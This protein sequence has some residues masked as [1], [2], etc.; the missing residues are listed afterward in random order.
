MEHESDGNTNN[1]R[2]TWYFHQRINTKT[3]GRRNKKT[4][5][6]HSNYSIVEISQNTKK[7]SGDLRRLFVTHTP[8][9]NHPLTQSGFFYDLSNLL[10]NFCYILFEEF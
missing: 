8:M 7:S 6:E 9:E 5:R 10:V 2:R 4:S 1:N 3:R